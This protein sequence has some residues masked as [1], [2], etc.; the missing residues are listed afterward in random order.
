MMYFRVRRGWCGLARES[1]SLNRLKV[2]GVGAGTH[3]DKGEPGHAR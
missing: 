1:V 2:S 3:K